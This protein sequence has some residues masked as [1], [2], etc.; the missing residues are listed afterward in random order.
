MRHAPLT[1]AH[2][3]AELPQADKQFDVVLCSDMLALHEWRGLVGQA[4]A[5]V[6]AVAYFHENQLTYPLSPTQRDDFHYAYTNILTAISAETCWFNSRFHL[7]DFATA[8]RAF[9]KRMPDN[10]H[11]SDFDAAIERADV[12][13]PGIDIPE[14]LS[15]RNRQ[16][17][18]TIVWVG[19]W[20][21]DKRPEKFAQALCELAE[22]DVPFDLILLGEQFDSHNDI[23]QSLHDRVGDR[24]LHAGFAPDKSAY[25]QRL[26]QSDIV[27]STADHEFFGI[28]ICEAVAAGAVPLL[29][30]RLAYPEV[31]PL[32]DSESR[33]AV[34]YDGSHKDLVHHLR[35]LLEMNAGDRRCLNVQ[36]RV[37]VERRDWSTLAVEY[38]DA[39]EA[40]ATQYAA[41]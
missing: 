40:V 12:M 19:R 30:E 10:R 15:R 29:P 8:A 11:L 20:Q 4:T 21:H 31:F 38:D 6:P 34:F 39:L 24:I 36:C 22:Q 2:R 17:T 35:C 1:L 28:A 16:Q 33:R 32:E 25:W 3:F 26:Q 27:V 5:S 23:Y 18:C 9:L 7:N 13:S 14:A 37:H 41:A